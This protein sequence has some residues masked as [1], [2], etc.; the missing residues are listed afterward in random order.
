[1]TKHI[2][3]QSASMPR[4][5]LVCTD[6]GGP[7]KLVNKFVLIP[8]IRACLAMARDVFFYPFQGGVHRRPNDITDITGTMLILFFA[9]VVGLF[10]SLG[11]FLVNPQL[12]VAL[13]VVS[14]WGSAPPFFRVLFHHLISPVKKMIAEAFNDYFEEYQKKMLDKSGQT[15]D[16]KELPP[17]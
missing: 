14:L 9:S 11:L 12:S 8:A 16:Q 13:F 4:P 15:S 1:M 2:P 3:C 17:H 6:E 5:D 10:G 7:P